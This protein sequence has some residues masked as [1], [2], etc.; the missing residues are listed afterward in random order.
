MD[1][2]LVGVAALMLASACGGSTSG[3]DDAEREASAVSGEGSPTQRETGTAP[4]P[5][6]PTGPRHCAAATITTQSALNELD[7]CDTIDGDLSIRLRDADLLPLHAL[8]RVEGDLKVLSPDLTT[9]VDSLAGL[10]QLEY[11]GGAAWFERLGITTLAPLSRLRHAR[12]LHLNRLPNLVQLEGLSQLELQG[13]VFELSEVPVLQSLAP[14][15]FPAHLQD[16]L[17]SEAPSLSDPGDVSRLESVVHLQLMGTALTTLQGLENLREVAESV[18]LARNPLLEDV[19]ALAQLR[20]SPFFTFNDNPRLRELPVFSALEKAYWISI[21]RNAALES[22]GSYPKLTVVSDLRV[23][24]NPALGSLVGFNNLQL[25]Y[26]IRIQSN[27]SLGHIEF[28]QLT[29]VGSSLVVTS[30]PVL[31]A[32]TAS[33]FATVHTPLLKITGN[34]SPPLLLDPCPWTNDSIC[35]EA[36]QDMLCAP[37]TDTADCPRPV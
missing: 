20:S 35:D 16:L 24:D 18:E 27:A 30:N 36:P 2:W 23:R 17:V 31:D 11:I 22:A 21:E 25:S 6:A 28:P 26:L 12:E 19:S 32:N 13:G 4:E 9:T 37:G 33:Q 7:G 10:E 3:A 34:Q 14:L 15:V 29:E 5:A 8:R 1:R